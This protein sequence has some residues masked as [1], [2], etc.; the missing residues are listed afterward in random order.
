MKRIPALFAAASVAALPFAA[1]AQTPAPTRAP[2]PNVPAPLA[3]TIGGLSVGTVVGVT[4]A[5]FLI[6]VVASGGDGDS[7][8]TTT[9]TT[10]TTTN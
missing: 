1:A 2:S 5:G 8:T 6:V 7:S 3:N 9:T 4:A 10:T